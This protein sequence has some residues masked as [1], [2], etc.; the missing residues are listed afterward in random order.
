[1]TTVDKLVYLIR[2]GKI[3]LDR[4]APQYREQVVAELGTESNT[5]EDKDPITAKAV[6]K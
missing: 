3:T 2:R 6:Q 1:M 5:E 4:V